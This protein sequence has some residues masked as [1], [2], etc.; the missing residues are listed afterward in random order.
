MKLGTVIQNPDLTSSP[1]ASPA[2][3]F[4]KQES[5]EARK[6]TATSGRKCYGL[7]E[8]YIQLGSLVKMLLDSSQWF[9]TK[10][11]LIWKKRSM[12]RERTQKIVAM[13]FEE[14][15]KDGELVKEYWRPSW[16]TLK[17]KDIMSSQLLFQLVPSTPRTGE[18]GSGLL[19]TPRAS[20]SEGAPVKNAEWNGKG[21][22]RTNAKGVRSGV[23]V[24]DVLASVNKER[25][26]RTGMLP[27]PNARDTKGTSIKRDRIPD[28][29]ECPTGT[30]TGLKLHSDFVGWMM[31]YPKGWCD[32][33]MVESS[34]KPNTATNH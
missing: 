27:T 10:V 5:G 21:W 17:E 18:I 11:D 6:M 30:K 15:D 9:S 26:E 31:G 29:V 20:E 1:A 32:F 12:L 24:K 19:H 13:K 4:P 8:N 22:S 34:V 16:Q 23:K 25:A 14:K 33:P 3:L 7:Y 2:S 28:V